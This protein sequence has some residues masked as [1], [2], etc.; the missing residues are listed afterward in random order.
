MDGL[1]DVDE[2]T[3]CRDVDERLDCRDVARG[4]TVEMMTSG[5]SV[6]M[7]S[8]GRTVE[9]SARGRTV[10][11]L[12]TDRTIEMLLSFV[13]T[14]YAMMSIAVELTKRGDVVELFECRGHIESQRAVL[15]LRSAG[16]LSAVRHLQNEIRNNLPTPSNFVTIFYKE[17]TRTLK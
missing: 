2:W 11:M 1:R 13:S 8:S 6:E 15:L 10:E 7:L 14:H 17:I 12:P 9:I 5:Q 16:D 3:D 4:W